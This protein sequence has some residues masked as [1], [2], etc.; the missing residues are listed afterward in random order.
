[1]RHG[2]LGKKLERL[3]AHRKALLRNLA[4]AF[5]QHERIVTTEAKCKELRRVAEKMITHAKQDTLHARRQAASYLQDK[6]VVTKLFSEIVPRIGDRKGGYT[7]ITKIGPR[8]GD[9][10]MLCAIE[11]VDRAEA[12]E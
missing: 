12:G 5:F 3:G 11:L 9:A 8:H 2:K 6:K 7:R 10:S 1:M 4:T